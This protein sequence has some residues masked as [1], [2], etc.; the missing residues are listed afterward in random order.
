MCKF[1]FKWERFYLTFLSK[2]YIAKYPYFLLVF[3][4][5]WIIVEIK[6]RCAWTAFERCSSYKTLGANSTG[7]FHYFKYGLGQT[8]SP[9]FSFTSQKREL[10]KLVGHRGAFRLNSLLFIKADK[11]LVSKIDIITNRLAPIRY[12]MQVQAPYNIFI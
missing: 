6:F 11:Y 5:I 8:I 9:G 12:T 1:I 10:I 4:L 7:L 2:K 3:L